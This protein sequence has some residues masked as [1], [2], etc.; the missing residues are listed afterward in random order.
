V[1]GL[2]IGIVGFTING[3]LA[4]H[5]VNIE[6]QFARDPVEVGLAL[7]DIGL[8][9]QKMSS[10]SCVNCRKRSR[11]ACCRECERLG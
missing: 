3:V 1:R 8:S 6:G 11:C 2:R 5:G 7:T 4:E 10:P 9:I